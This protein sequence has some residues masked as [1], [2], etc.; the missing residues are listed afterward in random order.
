[1][2]FFLKA[3]HFPLLDFSIENLKVHIIYAKLN[4]KLFSRQI[5]YM[6]FESKCIAIGQTNVFYAVTKKYS[7]G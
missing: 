6:M 1:M 3:K 4:N 7:L 2:P 5:P